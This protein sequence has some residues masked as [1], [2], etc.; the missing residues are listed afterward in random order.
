MG[1]AGMAGA[2]RRKRV[3]L[4][5]GSPKRIGSIASINFGP[6][7]SAAGNA[8]APRHPSAAATRPYGTA[9]LRGA[10]ATDPDTPAR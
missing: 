10:A 2:K 1:S 3:L 5:R 8:R 4:G 6:I 9:A 7:C